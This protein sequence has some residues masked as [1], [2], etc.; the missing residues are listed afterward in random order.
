MDGPNT[1]RC[2]TQPL[3]L[4]TLVVLAATGVVANDNW[5][6]FRGPNAGVV[7]DTTPISPSGGVPPSTW[8]GSWTWRGLAGAR[9]SSGMT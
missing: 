2:Y 9:R 4:A 3:V 8:R 1:C 6:Q 5:P 7:A